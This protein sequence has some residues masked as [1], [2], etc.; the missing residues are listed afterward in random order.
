MA[1][2]TEVGHIRPSGRAVNVKEAEP[3]RWQTMQVGVGAGYH[4]VD[5][6]GRRRQAGRC[7]GGVRFGQPFPVAFA[8]DRAGGGEHEMRG[9]HQ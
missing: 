6:F 9:G 2:L 5:F 4:L 1:L 7:V 3:G 8:A